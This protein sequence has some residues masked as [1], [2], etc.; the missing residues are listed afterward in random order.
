MYEEN[1]ENRKQKKTKM[2]FV[3]DKT[4]NKKRTSRWDMRTLPPEPERTSICIYIKYN[5]YI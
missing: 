4:S 2:V 1:I 3:Y 5:Y